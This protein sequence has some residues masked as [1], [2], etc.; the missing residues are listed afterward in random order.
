MAPDETKLTSAEP[1]PQPN[2]SASPIMLN[3]KASVAAPK[4]S[5]NEDTVEMKAT[6][7]PGGTLQVQSQADECFDDIFED[8]M[9]TEEEE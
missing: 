2:S 6:L 7:S 8:E 4:L 1:V 9:A 5:D 3:G